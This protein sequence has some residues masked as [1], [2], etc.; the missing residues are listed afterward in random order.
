[1]SNDF[2]LE[3]CDLTKKYKSFTAVENINI[4][5][6]QGEI[7]GFI[8]KNGA[9]KS[10]CM[11]MFSGLSHP[12]SGSITL[13]GYTGANLVKHNV[14]QY[15]GSL[16]ESPGM[17]PSMSA[18]EN[19]K[20][21]AYGI[22]NI[23]DKEIYEILEMVGLSAAAKRKSKG[24]SLGMK[25]R[26]G[27]AIALLNKPKFLI[28]DEPINGLDPQGIVEM[29][30]TISTLCEERGITVMISSHILEEVSKIATTIGI[31]HK[32]KMLKEF[33]TRSFEQ[34]SSDRIEISTPDVERATSLIKGEMNCQ[35][36]I[37]ENRNIIVT[38]YK[39]PLGDMI[40]TLVH[41]DVYLNKIIEKTMTLEQYYLAMT[42]D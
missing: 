33:D 40:N 22:G 23:T 5:V 25:Q 29:R 1:M 17:C 28:L 12:T 34:L 7:Y 4:H 11:K 41:H 10:T 31:I 13:M 42:S 8:G 18:Y 2:I 21:L 20:M 9:G 26:L 3:T 38:D 30:K 39:C 36:E 35:C 16:I 24:Y 19:L 15:V 37:D 27:I 14:F 32:G 6:K